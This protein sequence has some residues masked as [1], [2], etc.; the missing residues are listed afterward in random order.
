VDGVESRAK[1]FDAIASARSVGKADPLLNTGGSGRGKERFEGE[2]REPSS[3]G[4]G[5]PAGTCADGGGV[6]RSAIFQKGKRKD[7]RRSCTSL[8][9]QPAKR[10]INVVFT[11]RK[12]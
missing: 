12:P 8:G 11:G 10:L 4:C 1:K 6:K 3:E 7:K 2:V 9:Y 5:S